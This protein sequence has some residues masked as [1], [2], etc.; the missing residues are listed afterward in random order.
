ML[1]LNAAEIHVEKAMDCRKNAAFAEQY[2]VLISL[3]QK[4]RKV[5]TLNQKC[6]AL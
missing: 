3:Q 4:I 5:T 6:T 2:S 1:T